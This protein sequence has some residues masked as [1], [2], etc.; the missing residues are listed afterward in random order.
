MQTQSMLEKFLKQLNC[1][2][3]S[4]PYNNNALMLANHARSG[5][6]IQ[7]L[8]GKDLLKQNLEREAHRLKLYDTL[9]INLATDEI[10]SRLSHYEKRQFENLAIHANSINIIIQIP[11]QQKTN[12]SLESDFFNGTTFYKNNNLDP[13]FYYNNSSLF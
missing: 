2:I 10:W 4:P 7:T 8:T 3:Y 9:T 1:T 6:S 13:L 11:E 12:N 5:T